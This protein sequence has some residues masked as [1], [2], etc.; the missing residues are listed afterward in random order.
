MATTILV[1]EDDRSIIQL[2]RYNLEQ[3]R[4]RVLT[5]VDGEHGLRLA[6]Q[7][8]PDLIV[9]DL[10]LPHLSG[11]EVCRRLK[12]SPALRH[13][14]ILMLTAKASEVDK[15]TGLEL[16]ADDYVTKPFSVRELVARIRAVLRRQ[17]AP[18][19]APLTRCGVLEADWE[20]HRV[21]VRGRP[22]HLT[23]KEYELLKMFLASKGRVLSR[24]ALLTTVWGYDQ[25]VDLETRTVDF[26]VSRLRRK[27]QGEAARLQ[28]VPGT[29][30][31]FLIDERRTA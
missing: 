16:G 10:L 11:L 23:P 19:H 12:R 9:L 26:H 8:R 21:T 1:I 6:D 15:V 18:I 7:E 14:P 13:I 28:T 22:V 4:Y 2:L 17:E 24:E 3:E 29:G 31:Q 25:A 30:Y 27:L 20:R 5:S